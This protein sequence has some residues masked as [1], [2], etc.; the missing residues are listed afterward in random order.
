[1]SFLFHNALE[2]QKMPFCLI[3]HHWQSFSDG[4]IGAIAAGVIMGVIML[5]LI[6]GGILDTQ[7]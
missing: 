1:M 6:I 2:L 7:G 3:F 4:Q 5:A